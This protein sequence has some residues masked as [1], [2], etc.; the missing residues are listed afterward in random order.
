VP[1]EAAKG[2]VTGHGFSRADVIGEDFGALAPDSKFI[3]TRYPQL[4]ESVSRG[5]SSQRRETQ[6]WQLAADNWRLP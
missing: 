3:S 2:F 5:R 6:N 1:L 4:S